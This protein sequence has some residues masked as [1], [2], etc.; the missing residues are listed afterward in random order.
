MKYICVDSAQR[1]IQAIDLVSLP[2]DDPHRHRDD[3]R[4]HAHNHLVHAVPSRVLLSRARRARA[5]STLRP[6]RVRIH[7]RSPLRRR[8]PGRCPGKPGRKDVSDPRPRTTVPYAC[9]PPSGLRARAALRAYV[10][11]ARGAPVSVC[12]RPKA[13]A[14]RA[15][16]A[17]GLVALFLR[18]RVVEHR[19]RRGPYVAQQL[20]VGVGGGRR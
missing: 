18:E 10:P 11:S 7:A 9:V 4:D 6:R 3:L 13:R 20:G 16:G 19:R 2:P 17:R 1:I 5:C 8:R 12:A 14:R 15:C